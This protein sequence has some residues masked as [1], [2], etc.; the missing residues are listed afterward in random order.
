MRIIKRYPNRKL[1]DTESRRYV[2]LQDVSGFVLRGEKVRIVDHATD[3]D[4]TSVTLCRALLE[5]GVRLRRPIPVEFL[6]SLLRSGA[7]RAGRGGLLRTIAHLKARVASLERRLARL[8][9]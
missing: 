2:R 1:Y 8:K 5:R 9:R 4:L 3:E 7:A 6:T